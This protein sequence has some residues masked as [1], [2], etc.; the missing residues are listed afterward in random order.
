[1]EK[2]S[3]YSNIINEQPWLNSRNDFQTWKIIKYDDIC[4]IFELMGGKLREQ[5]LIALD[6]RILAVC[7]LNEEDPS[8][9]ELNEVFRKLKSSKIITSIM[10]Q[11]HRN[12]FFIRVEYLDKDTPEIF[13]HKTRLV[14]ESLGYERKELSNNKSTTQAIQHNLYNPYKSRLIFG[15]HFDTCENSACISTPNDNAKNNVNDLMPRLKLFSSKGNSGQISIKWEDLDN[16]SVSLVNSFGKNCSNVQLYHGFLN[17]DV[18][19]KK[20]TENSVTPIWVSQC[21]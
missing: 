21:R 20:V 9:F 19:S 16:T 10:N 6:Q 18:G 8:R 17:V 13:V 4:P 15:T 12:I 1:G 11:K 3:T 5:V 2:E 14:T 7:N